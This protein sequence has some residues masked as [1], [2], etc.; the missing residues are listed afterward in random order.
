MPN[1]DRFTGTVRVLRQPDSN[2]RNRSTAKALP[3]SAA[4][5]RT[6][7]SGTRTYRSAAPAISFACPKCGLPMTAPASAAGHS[8]W[9]E[10]GATFVVPFPEPTAPTP[11]PK[12]VQYTEE[13]P[14]P[15][16]LPEAEPLPKEPE[17]GESEADYLFRVRAEEAREE[18][19][20]KA[21]LKAIVLTVTPLL[22]LF[23]CWVAWGAA[24]QRIRDVERQAAP[25]T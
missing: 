5:A 2:Q 8:G 3:G 6:Q 7:S 16:P 20:R 22:L 1:R 12:V 23:L 10:C 18:R 11:P 13:S 17:P 14:L 24:C 15:L 4:A 19:R 21:M 25:D 9:C